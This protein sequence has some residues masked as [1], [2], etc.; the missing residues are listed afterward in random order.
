MEDV[1]EQSRQS[2]LSALQGVQN[3]GQEVV[4][5]CKEDLFD[6]TEQLLSERDADLSKHVEALETKFWDGIS[7]EIIVLGVMAT[8]VY[9][10]AEW[11]NIY[12][13]QLE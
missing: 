2:V 7:Q 9:C 12:N 8:D 13:R 3:Q 1:C 11:D 4:W 10:R 5:L 6:Q